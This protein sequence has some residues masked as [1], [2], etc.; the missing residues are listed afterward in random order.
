MKKLNYLLILPMAF[1]MLS[2]GGSKKV[3]SQNGETTKKEKKNKAS[4]GGMLGGSLLGSIVEIPTEA[5]AETPEVSMSSTVVAGSDRQIIDN[6]EIE[7]PKFVLVKTFVS[8]SKVLGLRP[9]QSFSSVVSSLG[10]PYDI[11]HKDSKGSA[12]LYFYKT[13]NSIFDENTENEVNSSKVGVKHDS[14]LNRVYLE[15]DS[16]NNLVKVV[17]NEGL[18][19]TR[20]ILGFNKEWKKYWQILT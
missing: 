14:S 15:F 10:D 3:V 1:L 12:Y 5:S 9:G 2:C 7:E 11:L 17:T 20:T 18:S 6:E 4:L 13:I 8:I 16:S 19:N